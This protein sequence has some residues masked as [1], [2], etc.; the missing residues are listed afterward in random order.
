MLY[1][2]F[3]IFFLIY[4]GSFYKTN[5]VSRTNTRMRYWSQLISHKIQTAVSGIRW[6]ISNVLLCC[7]L[8][9]STDEVLKCNSSE[10][11]RHYVDNDTVCIYQSCY[12]DTRL[13]SFAVKDYQGHDNLNNLMGM[14]SSYDW[15]IIN[16]RLQL[17]GARMI[18]CQNTD[19][20]CLPVFW[21]QLTCLERRSI[22]QHII[23]AEVPRTLDQKLFS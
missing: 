21:S 8:I 15:F 6:Y 10:C 22:G 9:G 14:M 2:T 4:I 12:Q 11:L 17:N 20:L 18:H 13:Y 19:V 3:S 1:S 23:A 16:T 5:M 7:G